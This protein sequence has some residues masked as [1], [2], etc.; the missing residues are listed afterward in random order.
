MKKKILKK[1]L[2]VLLL[3]V[4]LVTAVVVPCFAWEWN[5]PAL[6]KLTSPIAPLEYS[7]VGNSPM[8]G[9]ISYSGNTWSTKGNLLTLALPD[10]F[11]NSYKE[12]QG[13]TS[14]ITVLGYDEWEWSQTDKEKIVQAFQK[15]ATTD[16]DSGSVTPVRQFHDCI[17]MAVIKYQYGV[18]QTSALKHF[19]DKVSSFATHTDFLPYILSYET[20]NLVDDPGTHG[21]S[22]TAYYQYRTLEGKWRSDM[23]NYDGYDH[24]YYIPDDTRSY[25]QY[26][27]MIGYAIKK[28]VEA[29]DD[30][31]PQQPFVIVDACYIG[32][33]DETGAFRVV[34]NNNIVGVHD[35]FAGSGSGHA[36][37]DPTYFSVTG[38]GGNM[39]PNMV[40][41]GYV[42][43]YDIP[44]NAIPSELSY[45]TDFLTT[46]L[47]GFLS[48]SIIPGITLGGI[49]ATVICIALFL[50]FLKIFAGG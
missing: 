19:A 35:S 18:R 17:N 47:G 33:T 4:V 38:G 22:A 1:T 12:I 44:A 21:V 20:F 30:F 26:N 3:S 36:T 24:S 13:D 28:A 23:L 32:T 29:H 43:N 16:Y 9:D 37:F 49:L 39:L 41:T 27:C 31:D 2:A 50:T 8:F 48:F 42:S 45:A 5:G 15:A 46:A 10:N 6:G 34:M 40:W 7:H 11:S 25:N 14:Q